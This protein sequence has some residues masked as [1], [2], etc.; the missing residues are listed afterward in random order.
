[1]SSL[2][3]QLYDVN[4]EM[5]IPIYK[6]VVSLSSVEPNYANYDILNPKADEPVFHLYWSYLHDIPLVQIT[7]NNMFYSITNSNNTKIT[8]YDIIQLFECPRST[9]RFNQADDFNPAVPYD[10]N[11]IKNTPVQHLPFLDI[12]VLPT[13]TV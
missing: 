1:M 5:E 10:I 3:V 9:L 4:F 12:T 6:G 13:H 7:T 2:S 8:L 11:F